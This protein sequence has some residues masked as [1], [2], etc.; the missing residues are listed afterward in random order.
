[1]EY[2]TIYQEL[3]R[4]AHSIVLEVYKTTLQFPASEMFGLTNQFRR[5][6][7]SVAANLAE[8]YRKA[9]MKDKLRVYNISLCSLEECRYFSLLAKDLG[10]IES[11]N[12]QIRIEDF[13]KRLYHYCKAIENKM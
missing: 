5:A 9:S 4:E 13:G 11:I 3:F 2:S 10:F 1:M 6:A 7:V 12:L 8:G